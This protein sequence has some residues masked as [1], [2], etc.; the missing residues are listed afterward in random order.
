MGFALQA[1]TA[2]A[3]FGLVSPLG[4]IERGRRAT[5]EFLIRTAIP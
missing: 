3:R 5:S 2:G 4:P 1:Q